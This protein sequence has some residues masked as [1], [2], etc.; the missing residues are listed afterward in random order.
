MHGAS[1]NCMRPAMRAQVR[2]Y[3][4]DLSA[5]VSSAE[6][7]IKAAAAQQATAAREAAIQAKVL[8]KCA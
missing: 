5:R 1:D 8:E 4:A 2:L 7:R 3:G 6:A